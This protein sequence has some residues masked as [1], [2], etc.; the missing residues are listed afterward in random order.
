MA[1]GGLKGCP[2]LSGGVMSF[3]T[4]F[5]A[6]FTGE[7]TLPYGADFELRGSRKRERGSMRGSFFKDERCF[8]FFF[9]SFIR[10]LLGKG[11]T[12]NHL[13]IESRADVPNSNVRCRGYKALGLDASSSWRYSD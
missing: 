12:L 7:I 2:F 11:E 1:H 10:P 8:F 5:Q 9:F 6:Y 13:G 3:P 4:G